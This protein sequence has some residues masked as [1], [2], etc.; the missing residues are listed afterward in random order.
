MVYVFNT[1]CVSLLDCYRETLSVSCGLTPSLMQTL[2][3]TIVSVVTGCYLVDTVYAAAHIAGRTP[4][5]RRPPV[6]AVSKRRKVR[7]G[8]FA[9]RAYRNC[10]SPTLGFW[11]NSTTH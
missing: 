9:L 4:C 11:L 5:R 8:C 7:T 3:T 1:Y 10:L 2:R 6:Y